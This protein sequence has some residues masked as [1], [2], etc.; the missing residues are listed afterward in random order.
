MRAGTRLGPYEITSSLG[1][2]GMGE[3]YRARDG[4]LGRDV[5]IKVVAAH[6]TDAPQA[7]ER[8]ERE[9]RSVAGLQHPNICTVY[10]VGDADGHAF[11]VMELLQGETLQQCLQRGPLALSQV[12]DIGI[13]L[14]DAL[15]V[16]HT[17]GIVHRDIKPANIFLTGRGPK[18]LDFGLA[19]TDARSDNQT[20]SAIETRGLLTES[21]AVVGTATYMSPEQLRGET[22]DARTDLFS[23]G[24]VLYEMAVGRPA[25][26]GPTVAAIGAAILHQPPHSL[27]SVRPELPEWFEQIVLKAL[28]KDRDLR[29]QSAGDLRADLQRRSSDVTPVSPATAARAPR[30]SRRRLWVGAAA[31]VATTAAAGYWSFFTTA[32]PKL[33]ESDT[34]VVSDFTNT[35]GDR[36]STTRSARA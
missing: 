14:A 8:F 21:G 11:I 20:A 34:I 36:C 18:I 9:A 15:H 28:D 35:T 3:V 25:F 29:Y 10:D 13:A 2:G 33:T 4:R 5:A 7:R 30:R 27:R 22:V 19:K 26:S 12:L 23:L 24:L 31:L 1:A 16:A 6:S 17:A 32:T